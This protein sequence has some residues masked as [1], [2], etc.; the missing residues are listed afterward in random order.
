[1][2][3]ALQRSDVTFF[4]PLLEPLT[5]E[6]PAIPPPSQRDSISYLAVRKAHPERK[7]ECWLSFHESRNHPRSGAFVGETTVG[8]RDHQAG[9]TDSRFRPPL[10]QGSKS[11]KLLAR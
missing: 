4:Y 1:V 9:G 8:G 10:K 3:C 5:G 11:R 6:P 2:T 7:R